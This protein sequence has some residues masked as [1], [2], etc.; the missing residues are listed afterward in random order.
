MNIFLVD[1]GATKIRFGSS[2]GRR[3]VK[4][5]VRPTPPA[6]R[7][8]KELFVD[9]AEQLFGRQKI[10]RTI[11]GVP[12]MVNVDR[13]KV[14]TIP[15]LPNWPVAN[16][17]RDLRRACGSIV[18]VENDAVLNALGEA[19]FGAGRGRRIVGFLTLSTGVNGVRIVDCKPDPQSFPV[20][21]RHL[22][23]RYKNKE[24]TLGH[25]IS[26]RSL[27]NQYKR[28]PE[29]I[30]SPAV[31]NEVTQT[32]AGTLVNLGLIWTP[33]IIVIGGSVTKSISLLKL[34]HEV[35]NRWHHR[36]IPPPL[37]KGKLGDLSGLYGA[38]ALAR[39]I[40]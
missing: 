34:R 29:F 38:L 3:I 32:L 19:C 7:E 5:I 1:I 40:W 39:K 22:L 36:L 12:G 4:T 9:A 23:V 11:V 6:W 25:A 37:A 20:E 17:V 14:L 35:G 31:W 2:D 33:D 30:R 16:I 24:L 15:N 13:T 28:K 27:E 21:L 8:A 26:G 10:T 18:M